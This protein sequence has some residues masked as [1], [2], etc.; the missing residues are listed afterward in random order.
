MPSVKST[1]GERCV[2]GDAPGADASGPFEFA[3]TIDA[4]WIAEPIWCCGGV[5]KAAASRRILFEP[6]E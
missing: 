2:P 5:Y 1:P 4:V 6:G 3:P